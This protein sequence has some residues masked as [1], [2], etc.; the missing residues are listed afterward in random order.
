MAT[1]VNPDEF[2][3]HRLKDGTVVQIRLGKWVYKDGG[4][5]WQPYTDEQL[6]AQYSEAE[7]V[8][9]RD[10]KEQQARNAKTGQPSDEST[11]R[12]QVSAQTTAGNKQSVGQPGVKNNAGDLSQGYAGAQGQQT[13]SDPWADI[14][15]QAVPSFQSTSKV[16][17]D[18]KNPLAD[19]PGGYLMGTPT[20][21]DPSMGLG[22]QQSVEDIL[23]GLSQKTPAEIKAIQQK[24]KDA[25][26]NVKVDGVVDNS[27]LAAYGQVL[28]S[29]LLYQSQGKNITPDEILDA[30]ADAGKKAAAKPKTSTNTS[31]SLT[32]PQ[33]ARATLEDAMTQK[34]G[35]RPTPQEVAQFTSALNA[36]ESQNP[37]TTTQTTTTDADGNTTLNTSSS[38][39]AA[40]PSAFASGYLLDAHG[41]EVKAI[42]HLNWYNV[43][44]SALGNGPVSTGL[45]T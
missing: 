40:S 32:D 28:Q 7:K 29:A 13:E 43:A 23:K 12:K 24:M 27:F 4:Q 3:L 8:H 38:G 18:H 14:S 36:Y 21:R 15:A 26:S 30:A 39:S 20:G 45:P 42:N 37:T 22:T 17:T 1:D 31:V 41:P 6:K 2:E 35:R 19:T 16:L 33:T 25:G 44:L 9:A 34:L 11:A 10:I 5:R